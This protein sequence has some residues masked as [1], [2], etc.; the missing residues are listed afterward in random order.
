MKLSRWLLPAAL[1]AVLS[2]T[3][4]C[5]KE[6]ATSSK[7]LEGSITLDLPA[8]VQVG[9]TKTFMI[10]TL[11]TVTCPDGDPVGYYFTDPDT[12]KRDTL[13]TSD[14]TFLKH[15]YTFTAADKRESQTLMLTAF[16]K[17][18]YYSTSGSAKFT[19]VRSGLDGK[20][21]VTGFDTM[22]STGRDTEMEQI[23]ICRLPSF[24]RAFYRFFRRVG[25][26]S[27]GPRRRP[28]A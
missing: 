28:P 4:G 15:H 11:M 19:I 8:F 12:S 14:G 17:S 25:R 1:V 20:G 18:G 21:S 26:G 13:V 6:Q 22:A 5:K 16:V 7:S 27:P 2:V 23:L 9:Y 10:D 3:A 24:R